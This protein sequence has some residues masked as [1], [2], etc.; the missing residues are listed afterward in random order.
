MY[1]KCGSSH[2]QTLRQSSLALNCQQHF[3]PRTFFGQYVQQKQ[4]CELQHLTNSTSNTVFSS[5]D[6]LFEFWTNISHIHVHVQVGIEA[7][8][9]WGPRYQYDRVGTS[10]GDEEEGGLAEGDA[11][12]R[13]EVGV[14]RRNS[15]FIPVGKIN[16]TIRLWE[17]VLKSISHITVTDKLPPI[18]PIIQEHVTCTESHGHTHMGSHIHVHT[19]HTHLYILVTISMVTPLLIS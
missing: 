16:T 13:V 3:D 1:V 2:S 7:Q 6:R 15:F 8:S 4:A 17:L 19:V 10:G 5:R 18:S 12:A 11:V 14:G 9:E